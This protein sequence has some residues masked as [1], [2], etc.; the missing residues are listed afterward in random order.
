[1]A[2]T[3]YFIALTAVLVAAAAFA[4]TDEELERGEQLYGLCVQ[5]HGAGGG[6]MQLSLAPAIAGL[7]AWYVESQ[8][9]LFR[10]GGRGVNPEDVG[11][12]RMHPMALYFDSE[13]WEADIAA[14]AA[15]VSSMPK[16]DPAPTLQG[17]DASKG[18]ATYGGLC[19][20]CHGPEGNGNQSMSAPPLAGASDWYLLESLKKYKARIRGGNP[21][22]NP[23]AALMTGFA[24][25]LADEQA[26]KDV[27][28]YI[29]TLSN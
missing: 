29:T 19:I 14:A 13:T 24:S 5:C 2:M 4:A 28:A 8:L 12:L 16:A 11:G 15:Y 7:P 22:Q 17:G 23:M 6:G 1:M 9:R 18:S 10:S 3:K 27:I 26:M 25:Q 21:S 20:S